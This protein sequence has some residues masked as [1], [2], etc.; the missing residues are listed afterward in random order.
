LY[1]IFFKSTFEKYK[2]FK[3][4]RL[5]PKSPEFRELVDRTVNM[6]LNLPAL[7][8]PIE[9]TEGVVN[10]KSNT[11][12]LLKTVVLP[13]LG[14]VAKKTEEKGKTLP[15]LKEDVKQNKMLPL[16]TPIKI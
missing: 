15:P 4:K 13:P 5:D 16:P 14:T 8:I 10:T 6:K 9:K 7:T 2:I 1:K 11:L 12:P 3:M